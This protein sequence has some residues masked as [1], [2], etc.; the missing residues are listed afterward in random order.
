MAATL[1]VSEADLTAAI[2]STEEA[3]L[4]IPSGLVSLTSEE[5][6]LR[7]KAQDKKGYDRGAEAS[8][9]M[10]IKDK[11]R[12]LGLEFEGKDP[13][14]FLEAY[15]SKVLADAKVA[16]SE[17]LKEKDTVIA[18]LRASVATLEM[19]KQ[20]LS[21]NVS[22]IKIDSTIMRAIPSNLIAG[23]EAD[24]VLLTMRNKGFEFEEVDGVVVAKKSG[25]LVADSALRPLAV[26]DVVKS[27]VTE[28]GW[29][30]EGNGGAAGKEG[31]GGGHSKAKTTA[32]STLSEAEKQWKD[33]G[34]NAGTA[35]F[36]S[37]VNALMKDNPQFN[38][39]D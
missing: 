1:K 30:D 14:K 19:D 26:T 34:K 29:I 21:A 24:E 36:Q 11:K 22:K 38:I 25:Q 33:S 39:N 37:H 16:P 20:S 10:L 13:S 28:R 31:R 12:E 15:Q 17:A 9:E 27:Y 32:A 6:T 8:V 3:E 2:T 7:D 23:V 18:G 5:L 35:E 4:A